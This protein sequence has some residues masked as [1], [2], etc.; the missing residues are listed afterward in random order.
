[1]STAAPNADRHGNADSKT[2][3]VSADSGQKLP[4]PLAGLAVELIAS[5]KSHVSCEF[6]TEKAQNAMALENVKRYKDIATKK[7]RD[8]S[9]M[10]HMLRCVRLQAEAMVKVLQVRR[11][12]LGVILDHKDDGTFLELFCNNFPWE[13]MGEDEFGFPLF[14]MICGDESH[15]SVPTQSALEKAISEIK[16]KE[17]DERD[18][19]KE[20]TKVVK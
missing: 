16:K 17:A 6:K 13:Y 2:T 1:M 12:I 14:E 8:Q 4:E 15:L 11:T 9:S 18:M 20:S 10:T 5:M 7:A 19:I 3:A